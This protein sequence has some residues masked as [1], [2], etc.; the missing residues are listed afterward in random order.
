MVVKVRCL[1]WQGLDTC[2]RDTRDSLC[3]CQQQREL[4][5]ACGGACVCVHQVFDKRK[6]I[7]SLVVYK[8]QLE[9]IRWGQTGAPHRAPIHCI[10]SYT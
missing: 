2:S 10:L 7:T 1:C 6:D 9:A 8:Q 3:V 4:T 5:T